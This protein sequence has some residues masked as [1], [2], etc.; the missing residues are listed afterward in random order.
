MATLCPVRIC[1]ATFTYAKEQRAEEKP[2]PCTVSQVLGPQEGS[3][4]AW[5]PFRTSQCP[6]FFRVCSWTGRSQ[7][8]HSTLA[9]PQSPL[10]LV[11]LVAAHPR[12]PRDPTYLHW[13][14][15]SQ[16][17]PGCGR[18]AFRWPVLKFRRVHGVALPENQC[19][20]VQPHSSFIVR[21][22]AC[23]HTRACPSASSARQGA[24]RILLAAAC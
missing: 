4:G 20:H 10:P 14:R 16:L 6:V 8:G 9:G 1:S 22:A 18:A 17:Q 2:K 13:S 15:Q 23:N 24:M 11:H 3:P 19:D 21:S 5:P 12:L 7:L